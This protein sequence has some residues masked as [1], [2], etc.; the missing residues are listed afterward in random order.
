[1][2]DAP[3]PQPALLRKRLLAGRAAAITTGVVCAMF[4]AILLLHLLRSGWAHTFDAAIYTRSLWGV[5][6]GDLHNPLVDLHVLSIHFNLVLY[7]L[8]PFTR[9]AHPLDVLIVAQA[10]AFGATVG[11]AADAC[12]RIAWRRGADTLALVALPVFV[13]G[14]AMCT[15]MVANPFL[16]DVRP[17]LIGVPLILAG[18]LRAERRGDHDVGSLAWMLSALLVREEYMMVIVGAMLTTPF[19]RGLLDRWRLRLVGVGLAVGW[20]ATFWFGI[21]RWIGDGSYDKAQEVGTDFLDVAMNDALSV[22]EMVGYKVELLVVFAAAMGGLALLG[23]RHIGTSGPGLLFLLVSVRMQD[24]V[25]NFHYVLFVTPGL[26]AA[27]VAGYR[28]FAPLTARHRWLP[29]AVVVT[30]TATFAFSSALP[31]GGRFRAENF[32][33]MLN[34]KTPISPDDR[35]DLQAMHALVATVPPDV[36]AAVHWE[37]AAPVSDRATILSSQQVFESLDEGEVLD[38]ALAAITV[39]RARWGSLAA[40]LVRDRG[41]RLAGVAA[42]RLALLV[43]DDEP[44]RLDDAPERCDAP[45]LSWPDVGLAACRIDVASDGAVQVVLQRIDGAEVPSTTWL[46]ARPSDAPPGGGE[47]LLLA[48]GL[49]APHQVPTTSAITATAD[50]VPGQQ[51]TFEMWASGRRYPVVVRGDD[52]PSSFEVLTVPRSAPGA[53]GSD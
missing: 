6:N 53:P 39:P 27:G 41:F 30:A 25:L 29:F 23:W 8:A 35:V 13:A 11:L 48:G 22:A 46:L 45:P 26:V 33:L 15:P 34:D 16:F 24:L 50:H 37:L 17:D 19:G 49:V 51:V 40:V 43:R 31:G 32:A 3:Q 20:W 44:V 1:M 38:D 10:A 2:D 18:L 47:P 42:D 5:A 52:G 21:R 9:I 28:R 14:L 4:V 12:V 7:A 36:P